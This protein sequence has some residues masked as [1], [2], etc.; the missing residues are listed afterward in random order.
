MLN[1]SSKLTEQTAALMPLNIVP[2]PSSLMNIRMIE[3]T[4]LPDSL[5]SRCVLIE[6]P[7]CHPIKHS[8]NNITVYHNVLPNFSIISNINNAQSTFPQTNILRKPSKNLIARNRTQFKISKYIMCVSR[9]ELFY[10]WHYLLLPYFNSRRGCQVQWI[11][12]VI[13]VT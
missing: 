3:C 10:Y 13:L 2:L 5:L 7:S 11:T 9:L 12:P 6:R 4:I 1:E 8:T